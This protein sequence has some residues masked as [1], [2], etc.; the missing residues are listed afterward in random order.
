M[1]H[2][3]LLCITL[4]QSISLWWEINIIFISIYDIV[5]KNGQKFPLYIELQWYSEAY[6]YYYYYYFSDWS[7]FYQFSHKFRICAFFV[8]SVTFFWGIQIIPYTL[9]FYLNLNNHP[10]FAIC[11]S[12]CK[13]K[14]MSMSINNPSSTILIIYSSKT[15]SNCHHIVKNS[16]QG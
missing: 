14:H 2:G 15:I 16:V 8:F 1:I 12:A 6:Y 11:W 3:R 13:E 10:S 7:I 9:L 5:L 4:L